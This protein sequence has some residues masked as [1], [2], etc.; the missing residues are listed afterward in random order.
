MR[1]RMRRWIAPALVG[2]LVAL[3]VVLV[4]LHH[5]GSRPLPAAR[6]ADDPAVSVPTGFAGVFVL[7][8]LLLGA[9][10]LMQRK[11]RRGH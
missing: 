5:T 7:A 8:A 11:A 10:A 3:A 2:G 4:A 6:L 1:L 9:L